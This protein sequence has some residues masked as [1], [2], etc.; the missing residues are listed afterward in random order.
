MHA[1][2]N[3]GHDTETLNTDLARFAFLLGRHDAARF[4]R[5][6][7]PGPDTNCRKCQ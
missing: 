3:T 6:Q 5:E 1:L 7:Q 2:D 4:F